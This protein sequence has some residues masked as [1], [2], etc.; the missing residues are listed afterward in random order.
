M[1]NVENGGHMC[2]EAASREKNGYF[3]KGNCLLGRGGVVHIIL[4]DIAG[5]LSCSSVVVILYFSE[6]L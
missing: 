1:E 3:V 2:Q 5:I 4:F 6:S